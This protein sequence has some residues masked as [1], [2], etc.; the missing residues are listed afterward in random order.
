MAYKLQ[1]IYDVASSF[2]RFEKNINNIKY[3]SNIESIKE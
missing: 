1:Q 3:C 2:C